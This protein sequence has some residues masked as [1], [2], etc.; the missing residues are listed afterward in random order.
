MGQ[1]RNNV[2]ATDDLKWAHRVAQRS[3]DPLAS[4]IRANESPNNSDPLN[5]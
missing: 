1:A 4:D 2:A 5:N 3:D